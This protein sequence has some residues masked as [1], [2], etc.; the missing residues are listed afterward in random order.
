MLLYLLQH[1]QTVR[2]ERRRRKKIRNEKEEREREK[3]HIKYKYIPHGARDVGSRY[4]DDSSNSMGVTRNDEMALHLFSLSLPSPSLH[5][6]RYIFSSFLPLVPFPFASILSSLLA[7]GFISFNRR[8]SRSES[9][10]SRC[11]RS[12]RRVRIE[13]NTIHILLD[14]L[15]LQEAPISRFESESVG[16]SQEPID[17]FWIFLCIC[18]CINL[19]ATIRIRKPKERER[20]MKMEDFL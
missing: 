17:N 20:E 1:E 2:K 7:S 15:Q 14:V 8:S 4:I 6:Y 10:S 5:V 3:I 9:R 18:K 13:Y 12:L 11:I 19:R 16:S